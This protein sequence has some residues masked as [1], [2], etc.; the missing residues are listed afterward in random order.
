MRK[1]SLKASFSAVGSLPA[2]YDW[3]LRRISAKAAMWSC[4]RD[5]G[6][7]ILDYGF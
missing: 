7:E 2:P 6:G 5:M 1:L 4:G 3:L